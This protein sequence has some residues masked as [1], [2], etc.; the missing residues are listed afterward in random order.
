MQPS[1][2]PIAATT[3]NSSGDANIRMIA[4]QIPMSAKSSMSLRKD[5][6]YITTNLNQIPSMHKSPTNRGQD[7]ERAGTPAA[8][9]Q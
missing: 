1:L 3:D 9:M 2:A 7:D 8:Q 4:K 5:N 6:G